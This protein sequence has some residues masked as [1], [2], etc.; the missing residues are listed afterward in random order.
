M[1]RLRGLKVLVGLIWKE[2]NG[3]YHNNT[4]KASPIEEW[5][6]IAPGR[7]KRYAPMGPASPPVPKRTKQS[8]KCSNWLD[9]KVNGPQQGRECFMPLSSSLPCTDIA[10]SASWHETRPLRYCTPDRVPAPI[11]ARRAVYPDPTGP[12]AK[13]S[14]F[15]SPGRPTARA[16]GLNP[17]ARPHLAAP[18]P[19]AR[20]WAHQPPKERR[21]PPWNTP[22]N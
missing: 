9:L 18:G 5:G 7:P 6:Q 13:K 1:G 17:R 8:K 4:A 10:D 16:S 14:G 20:E 11:R 2:Q 12:S 21:P 22:G 19:L 15:D 3:L